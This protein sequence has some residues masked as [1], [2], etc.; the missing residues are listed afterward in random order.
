M[1]S[2]TLAISGSTFTYNTVKNIGAVIYLNELDFYEMALTGNTFE[3]NT[4]QN[5]ADNI[6]IK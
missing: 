1:Q 2:L 3:K 4:A 5:S 6:Y